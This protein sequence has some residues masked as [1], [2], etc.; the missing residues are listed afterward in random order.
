MIERFCYQVEDEQVPFARQL[1]EVS[2]SFSEGCA[3]NDSEVVDIKAIREWADLGNEPA[4]AC[5]GKVLLIAEEENL[6]VLEQEIGKRFRNMQ[7]LVRLVDIADLYHAAQPS[8]TPAATTDDVCKLTLGHDAGLQVTD[9]ASHI[10]QAA[11]AIV[12]GHAARSQP[13]S[14]TLSPSDRSSSS[15]HSQRAASV[16]R[17][18]SNDTDWGED[19]DT[20]DGFDRVRS[21]TFGSTLS[22]P[23]PPPI[24]STYVPS[25]GSAAVRHL[26]SAI[27]TALTTQPTTTATF[28]PARLGPAAAAAASVQP[29]STADT[30]PQIVASESK[31]TR[32]D[33]HKRQ[34]LRDQFIPKR[35]YDR[36][37]EY[38][39]LTMTLEGKLIDIARKHD[40]PN[41]HRCVYQASASAH[42]IVM[43]PVTVNFP[44]LA[45]FAVKKVT[46]TEAV[47][48]GVTRNI[49]LRTFVSDWYT[50]MRVM[51]GLA[52]DGPVAEQTKRHREFTT[53]LRILR[54][55]LS[56]DRMNTGSSGA[57]RL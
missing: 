29:R 48:R 4:K 11:R 1:G 26:S 9:R 27:R 54:R 51:E 19:S 55:I 41:F 32:E 33:Q 50:P 43:P 20:D 8:P 40:Y 38:D 14:P 42:P 12:V 7:Y 47:I 46:I 18:G 6:V 52:E 2:R 13:T 36:N 22:T 34:Q 49:E 16:S 35:I 28:A 24:R 53:M 23:V 56:G 37:V 31:C 17:G 10:L 30:W 3:V 25:S 39:A 15:N 21:M 44:D 45:K 57:V 5:S